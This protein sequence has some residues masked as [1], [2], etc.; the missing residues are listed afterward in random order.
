MSN[1]Y[2][3][4]IVGAS[5]LVGRT[6][7]RVLEEKNFPHISYTLF[8]SNKSAGSKIRFLNQ[9]YILC[10][11]NENSFDNHFDYAIFC[12]G[13]TVSK[14]YAPIAASKGCIAIDNSSYFSCSRS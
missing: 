10:E 7:L 6:V 5:G 9:D 4:A 2:K 12:A 1:N 8:S 14:N 11:L 13:G 3:V